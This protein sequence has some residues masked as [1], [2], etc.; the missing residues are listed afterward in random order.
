MQQSLSQQLKATADQLFRPAD[1]EISQLIP[2]VEPIPEDNPTGACSREDVATLAY[3][4]W[5][6][7]G[8]PVGS[9]EED[10]CRAEEWLRTKGQLRSQFVEP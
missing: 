6:S 7:R 9:P 4:L 5:H 8:C 3:Q 10:W 2:G 1:R